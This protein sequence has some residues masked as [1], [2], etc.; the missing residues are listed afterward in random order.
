MQPRYMLL[1]LA[2]HLRGAIGLPKSGGLEPVDLALARY[3]HSRHRVAPLLYVAITHGGSKAEDDAAAWLRSVYQ[4]NSSLLL[5]RK[6]AEKHLEKCFA[7]AG[8]YAVRIKG[9]DLAAQLYEH[10]EARPSK[11]IDILVSPADAPRA[12]RLMHDIGCIPEKTR[13]ARLERL[14]MQVVKDITFN[15]PKFGAQIELHQRLLLAEPDGFTDALIQSLDGE[16]A[17]RVSN[18]HYLLYLIMHGAISSW[19]RLKWVV[20]MAALLQ[21]TPA[22]ADAVFALARAYQCT[23]A[24]AAS[25]MMVDEIFPDMMPGAWRGQVE[26]IGSSEKAEKLKTAFLMMLVRHE[27][28]ARKIGFPL[29]D[30]YVWDGG[31]NNLTYAGRRALRPLMLRL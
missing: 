19:P 12:A 17:P 11:D 4:R 14:Y 26:S 18:N 28:I 21:K 20:D 3:A 30:R 22:Q 8:I 2:G 24:V 5:K 29:A 1:E 16:V 23:N 7:D 9:P 6:A 15:E 31:I 10:P 13:S 25:L 27:P